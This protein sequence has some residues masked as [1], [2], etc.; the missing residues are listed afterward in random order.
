MSRQRFQAI[1]RCVHLVDRDVMVEQPREPGYDSIV[2]TRWLLETITENFMHHYNPHEFMCCDEMMV[3]YWGRYCCIK[4]Y[5]PLKPMK[6][7]KGF[8]FCVTV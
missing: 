4:Q 5:M 6:H 2:H 7:G 3:P 8:G 1:L